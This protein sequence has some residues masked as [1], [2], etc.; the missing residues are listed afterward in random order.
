MSSRT[1]QGPVRADRS[2]LALSAL[3]SRH[4]AVAPGFHPS[5]R[6][7][8]PPSPPTPALHPLGRPR[9]VPCLH[10][11]VCHGHF[12][13]TESA[14]QGPISASGTGGPSRGV[15]RD[16]TQQVELPL[17]VCHRHSDGVWGAGAEAPART[18]LTGSVWSLSAAV[19][20][21]EV[22]AASQIEHGLPGRSPRPFW[23]LCPLVTPAADVRVVCSRLSGVWCRPT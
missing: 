8:P 5:G 15:S 7:R 13:Q 6:A 18:G 4:H 1:P 11:W 3:C 9:C 12:V 14:V 16:D 2:V 19:F 17:P 21:R 22:A 10:R 23:P 20:T